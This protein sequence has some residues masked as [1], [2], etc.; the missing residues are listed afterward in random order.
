MRQAI[1]TVLS[2]A[3]L[4]LVVPAVAADLAGSQWRPIAIG[5]AAWTAG[6]AFVR[7]EGEG[8]LVGRSGCNGFFG[9]YR[10]AG[11]VIEIGPLASTRKACPEPAMRDETALLEALAAARGFARDGIQLSLTDQAGEPTASFVQTDWD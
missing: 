9:S 3:L 6:E 5:T 7:F 11:D 2:M 8:R 1:V 10:L 4:G